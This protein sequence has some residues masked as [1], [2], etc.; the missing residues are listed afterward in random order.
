MIVWTWQYIFEYLKHGLYTTIYS[1]SLSG[2]RPQSSL[3]LGPIRFLEGLCPSDWFWHDCLVF[4]LCLFDWELLSSI[5][6]L[7]SCT[8]CPI[9]VL[10]IGIQSA[11]ACWETPINYFKTDFHWGHKTLSQSLLRSWDATSLDVTVSNFDTRGLPIW[12]TEW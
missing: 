5:R 11:L 7:A 10:Q 9:P 2:R 6:P 1:S 8:E 12:H 4:W 3:S